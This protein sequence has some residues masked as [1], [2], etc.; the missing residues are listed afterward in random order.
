MSPGAFCAR[1]FENIEEDDY[2]EAHDEESHK[3]TGRH[4]TYKDACFILVDTP[5]IHRSIYW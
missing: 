2:D 4:P 3:Y 1:F 5:P